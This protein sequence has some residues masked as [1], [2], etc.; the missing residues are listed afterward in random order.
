M[1][2]PSSAANKENFGLSEE[3]IAL[4]EVARSFAQEKIIP[5]AGKL[6]QSEEFPAELIA[7]AHRVGLVN[8]LQPAEL[9][10]SGLSTFDAALVTEELAAGCAGVTTS[11][12]ANDL[13]LTPILVGGSDEQKKRFIEPIARSGKLA[14]FC[15]TEPGAGSDAAG[16]TTTAVRDGAE[17]VI[18]GSKQW[19]TNGGVA[20]QYTV[21]ATIDK[22][23][24]HKGVCCFAVD[25]HSSGVV[26]GRHENK[27]GQRCSNTVR[28]TFDSV[29]VPAANLIGKEGEGFSIAMKTLDISR[30]LTAAIAVG[31]ARA[32]FEYA[33]GYAKERTQFGQAI[34][35]FQAIQ[36]MLA[37]M[38]TETEAARHLTLHSA[39]LL[40]ANI[41]ASLESSMAKRLAADTAMRVA[42]DAV[43][44]Y[45]GY[46]YTKDYP[47]EKLMRDAKLLQ[48]YEGTSQIQRLVIA[49]ELLRC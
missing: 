24:R 31:I 8:L 2:A 43:Q 5:V 21:F 38:Y 40:D 27:M 34:S 39:R 19:I 46:G 49:R 7:E 44:I 48:I 10:G 36:F 11:I 12:V 20:S 6:D 16:I 1:V 41:P 23:K 17:Y 15:L 33:C 32:A 3:Q 37:D 26:K 45:G 18:N 35:S 4:R 47:V 30:P 22:S 9:G 28:I 14:S 25:A 29:R 42:T 13:A